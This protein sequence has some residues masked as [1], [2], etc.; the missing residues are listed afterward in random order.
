M[1]AYFEDPAIANKFRDLR[2]GLPVD[3][4]VVQ[5]VRRDGLK[6][7]QQV[8]QIAAIFVRPGYPRHPPNTVNANYSA[9][10]NAKYDALEL[11]L[12]QP[13]VTSAHVAWADLGRFRQFAAFQLVLDPRGA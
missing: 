11:A 2:S 8:P 12:N 3:R 7:L 13:L 4:T 5:L 10:M 6:A 1:I 9:T